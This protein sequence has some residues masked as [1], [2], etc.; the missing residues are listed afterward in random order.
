MEPARPSVRPAV[1]LTWVA[2]LIVALRV[3]EAAGGPQSE[4][5]EIPP[6]LVALASVASL[7]VAIVIRRRVNRFLAVL[8]A[9]VVGGLIMARYNAMPGVALGAAIGSLV[10]WAFVRR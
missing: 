5:V 1:L 3:V 8:M 9:A 4:E 7:A 2:V 10:A 6:L